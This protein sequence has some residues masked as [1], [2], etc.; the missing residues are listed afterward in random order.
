MV[1]I[2]RIER[3]Q[4]L[5]VASHEEEGRKFDGKSPTATAVYLVNNVV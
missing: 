3:T 5:A 2:K 4:L 1:S